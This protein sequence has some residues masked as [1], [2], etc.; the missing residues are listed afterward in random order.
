MSIAIRGCND[1]LRRSFPTSAS[2]GNRRATRNGV[3]SILRPHC[4]V[5][6]GSRPR[7]RG[8]T[9]GAR[10]LRPRPRRDRSLVRRWLPA[11]AGVRPLHPSLLL[12]IPPCSKS[13]LGGDERRDGDV[14]PP[15]ETG[16]PPP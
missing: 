7:R 8:L 1:L 11:G 14:C 6:L 5:G 2:S 15:S 3:R 10:R 12:T 9:A 13:F 16:P 4:R